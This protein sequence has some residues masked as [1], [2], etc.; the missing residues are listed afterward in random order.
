M[1][2]PPDPP[3]GEPAVMPMLRVKARKASGCTFFSHSED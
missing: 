3:A 2:P 1:D